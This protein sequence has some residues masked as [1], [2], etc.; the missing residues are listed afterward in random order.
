[1][2]LHTKY[3]G[4]ISYEPHE[5]I[6]FPDGLFG[7][8]TYHS[9]LLIRLEDDPTS[10]FCLQ[11]VEEPDLAFILLDPFRIMPE[12]APDLSDE[13]CVKLGN[14][15]VEDL[16]LYVTCVL[17]KPVSESTVNLRCPIVVNIHTRTAFQ[18]ILHSDNGY[19]FQTKL[20]D[21]AAKG[22]ASC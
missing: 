12:Y 21:F 10:P 22:D 5:L 18:V 20:Q 9:Y 19:T 2:K 11:S 16:A 3:C 4:E 6:A 15:A 8:E 1:M 14:P 17:R 13:D 7:F